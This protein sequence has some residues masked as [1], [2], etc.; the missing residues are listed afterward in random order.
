MSTATCLTEQKVSVVVRDAL[1]LENQ[2]V[3]PIR[4]AKDSSHYDR[5]LQRLEGK[6][7][8]QEILAAFSAG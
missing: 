8:V 1:R 4:E 2:Q 3:R 6:R 5:M 7:S